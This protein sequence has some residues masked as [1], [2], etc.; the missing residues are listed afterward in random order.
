MVAAELKLSGLLSLSRHASL[1]LSP[2]RRFVARSFTLL[3][4]SASPS[5]H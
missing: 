4:R 5:D 2:S 3:F 1:S